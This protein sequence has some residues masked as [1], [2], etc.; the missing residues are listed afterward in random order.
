MGNDRLNVRFIIWIG[1]FNLFGYLFGEFMIIAIVAYDKNRVIGKGNEIPW[2]LPEDL[3]LFKK[4]TT[5]HA[6]IM[7]RKTWESIPEK[8]RPLP[9]RT[10]IVL[11]SAWHPNGPSSEAILGPYFTND[12]DI[13]LEIAERCRPN[14]DIFVIGGA[15]IYEHAIN[16]AD[17]KVDRILASL[18]DGEYEGDVFFPELHGEW[19]EKTISEH[20]GFKL[21]EKIRYETCIPENS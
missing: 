8:Y 5:D 6:V 16:Q 20:D 11:T 4:H 14:K 21:I 12:W 2:R 17:V 3:K 13:A 7:G 1:M 19:I 10:N 18:V 9:N 15:S